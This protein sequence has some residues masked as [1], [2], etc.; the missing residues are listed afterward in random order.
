MSFIESPRQQVGGH[1]P[2]GLTSCNK[3]APADASTGAKHTESTGQ[4][5]ASGADAGNRSFN[6][7]RLR[8][9]NEAKTRLKAFGCEVVRT[10]GSGSFIRR[11]S[12]GE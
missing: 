2:S 9:G 3:K 5:I 1:R 8:R 11:T 6:R 7:L 4:N 12:D 10:P